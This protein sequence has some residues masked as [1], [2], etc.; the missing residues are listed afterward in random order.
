MFLGPPQ[1]TRQSRSLAILALVGSS[2]ALRLIGF[3][4]VVAGVK[5]PPL[6]A[7]QFI[8]LIATI[9]IGLWKIGRGKTIEHGTVITKLSATISE[10]F[11]RATA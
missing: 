10:R 6:L 9:A 3:F 7:L 4:S 8:A 5:Q 11:A 2:T 1:T